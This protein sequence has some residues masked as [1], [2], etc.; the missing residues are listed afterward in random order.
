MWCLDGSGSVTLENFTV[1]K[2]F[3]RDV[4][5][6]FDVEGSNGIRAQVGAVQFST[7][8]QLEIAL[9]AYTNS[10]ALLEAIMDI[11]YL[12]GSTNTAAGLLKS[13]ADIE[14]F[15]RPYISGGA[16]LIIVVTDGQSDST[17]GTIEAANAARKAGVTVACITI[18]DK[19][20]FRPGE[21][22]GIVGGDMRLAFPI[23]NWQGIAD[24]GAIVRNITDLACNV[25]IRVDNLE[26]VIEASIPCNRTLYLLYFPNVTS[27]L[28]LLANIEGG[29]VIVCF[30]YT[31]P[32]P[33]PSDFSGSSTCSIIGLGSTR[34]GT[35]T[36]YPATNETQAGAETLFVSISSTKTEA[37]A[38][39]TCG[40]NF[41]L[42]AFYCSAVIATNVTRLSSS[43]SSSAGQSAW[44]R[45]VVVN[46]TQIAFNLTVLGDSGSPRCADC[47]AGTSFLSTDPTSPVFGICASACLGATQFS[48]IDPETGKDSCGSCDP[49]C[50]TCVAPGGPRSCTTCP[51]GAALLDNAED[52][53]F[54]SPYWASFAAGTAASG[55]VDAGGRRIV[56]S[57]SALNGA[58]AGRCVPRCP[59][60][61][62]TVATNVSASGRVSES[63]LCAGTPQSF[64]LAIG[65]A[66]AVDDQ[67]AA[68]L[69]STTTFTLCLSSASPL[70]P[71]GPGPFG[72]CTTTF[73]GSDLDGLL[74]GSLAS[75]L[76][77]PPAAVFLRACVNVDAD[78]RW[79]WTFGA[80]GAANAVNTS[81]PGAAA[82][83]ASSS[84]SGCNCSYLLTYAFVPALAEPGAA[85]TAV[86][87]AFA[88]ATLADTN[89]A[90]G[91]RA[92]A[93]RVA[94][95]AGAASPGRVPFTPPGGTGLPPPSPAAL[96]ANCSASAFVYSYAAPVLLD[97]CVDTRAPFDL[98]PTPV[99][100]A[101]LSPLSLC[102]LPEP[103]APAFNPTGDGP[104]GLHAAIILVPL[105]FALLCCGMCCFGYCRWRRR[106]QKLVEFHSR[107]R[108]T[109][110]ATGGSGAGAGDMLGSAR[111]AVTSWKATTNPYAATVDPFEP[112]QR[113]PSRLPSNARF[114]QT[115]EPTRTVV[116]KDPSAVV[117]VELTTVL[118]PKPQPEPAPAIAETLQPPQPSTE[119]TDPVGEVVVV[120]NPLVEAEQAA[121]PPPS[122][123]GVDAVEVAAPEAP[124]FDPLAAAL[125]G[126]GPGGG[127]EEWA[128][129]ARMPVMSMAQ[130]LVEFLAPGAVTLGM[131]LLSDK[132]AEPQAMEP[133]PVPTDASAAAR[134]ARVRNAMRQ[135]LPPPPVDAGPAVFNVET[136]RTKK[137]LVR[138][139]TVRLRQVN[140][141]KGDAEWAT[142]KRNLTGGGGEG[143]AP[144]ASP[145]S[146]TAVVQR[147][148][149]Y[150]E[151]K[152]RAVVVKRF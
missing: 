110:F 50:G 87:R 39:E 85:G 21:V 1:T 3:V 151:H 105:L 97:A 41:T 70:Y 60:G 46:G 56:P 144:A 130:Q 124:P 114:R 104:A 141:I 19:T 139:Q 11:G 63:L 83:A 77:V 29:N 64:A 59:A 147:D 131:G 32:E 148:V 132:P 28:S 12:T 4:T 43:N 121:E 38:N 89:A 126:M 111:T 79:V 35:T 120:P 118:P 82:A 108:S 31:S 73:P 119:T 5:S 36:A 27:P 54:S 140:E 8:A 115:F 152:G 90:A 14:Q 75:G 143:E 48:D 65:N 133:V 76:G 84:S 123:V 80:P 17:T 134:A 52:P 138:T 42:A 13:T 116:L 33:S 117:E 86:S 69:G 96:V 113:L 107:P 57:P 81:A 72:A 53:A 122:P 67:G 44:D 99:Q 55:A 125:D 103:P 58:R 6:F 22:E 61:Y 24:D 112:T 25:P 10:T 16:H 136:V 15:G 9:D 100:A 93:A 149:V 2:K 127:V 51:D 30:S 37:A 92:E 109:S 20:K 34:I 45:V 7:S 128:A 91:V 18:G 101:A 129:P 145:W 98:V 74:G 62:A 26:D 88:L 40:G 150:E 68:G 142:S 106:R 71:V 137:E 47:P 94:V 78:T 102:P 135:P 23:E 95:A 146:F 49:S 66:T